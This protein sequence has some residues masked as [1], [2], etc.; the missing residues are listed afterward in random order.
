ME[1]GPF[2]QRGG[3]GKEGIL[4]KAVLQLVPSYLMS[5]FQFPLSLCNDIKSLLLN[6]WWGGGVLKDRG[7]LHGEFGISCVYPKEWEAWVLKI[8]IFLINHRLQS[9][10]GSLLI[11]LCSYQVKF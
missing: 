4:I 7:K 8:F 10:H 2:F 11:I 3:G 5:I 1:K 6:F 9:K